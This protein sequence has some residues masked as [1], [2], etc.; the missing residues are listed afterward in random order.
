MYERF[1]I[2]EEE[3]RARAY[4]IYEARGS[5]TSDF[6][7][8]LEAEEQLIR[9]RVTAEIHQEL[10]QRDPILFSDWPFGFSCSVIG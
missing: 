10:K 1:G 5:Q 4:A 2:S 9:E 3:V 6:D 8:W 7:T